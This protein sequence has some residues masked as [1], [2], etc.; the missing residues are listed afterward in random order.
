MFASSEF[1]VILDQA[2]TPGSALL[3]TLTSL[4]PINAPSFF[5]VCNLLNS[6][7]SRA[8]IQPSGLD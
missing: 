1:D 8:Y 3:P 4:I 7:A 2:T 6:A 5:F